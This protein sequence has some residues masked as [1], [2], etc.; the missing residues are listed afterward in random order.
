MN[1]LSRDWTAV[2]PLR[3]GSKGLP[4]KNTRTLA[5]ECWG[6]GDESWVGRQIFRESRP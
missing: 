4:G 1:T 2:I 3:A 6:M 5:G